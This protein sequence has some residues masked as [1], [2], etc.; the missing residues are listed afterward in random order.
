MSKYTKIIILT[1]CFLFLGSL[2][3]LFSTSMLSESANTFSAGAINDNSNSNLFEE[4][5]DSA[6]HRS[7]KSISKAVM[8]DYV[9]NT[10]DFID[11]NYDHYI[12][13]KY[14][15]QNYFNTADNIDFIAFYKNYSLIKET[16][17]YL[18]FE[19][20]NDFEIEKIKIDLINNNIEI[21]KI[22]LKNE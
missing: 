2:F 21:Q 15:I 3:G 13:D 14:R 11:F 16:N 22:N 8:A 12:Y 1:V 6:L 10:Y 7:T 9:E 5:A 17:E 20:K 4:R 19:K 18:Y